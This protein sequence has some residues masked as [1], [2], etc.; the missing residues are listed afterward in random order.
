VTYRTYPHV[1]MADRAVEA[2]GLLHRALAGEI[3]PALVVARPPL[4]KGCD[5]GRT[6]NDGPMVRL[7][8]S[9]A[10]DVQE[11]GLLGI[12]INAGFPE[13]DVWA[14]GSSVIV[15]YDR[16]SCGPDLAQRAAGKIV[17]E[18]WDWRETYAMP[19][20]LADCMAMIDPAQ[21]GAPLVI[22]DY[23]DNPGSGAY[24]DC[25]ALLAALI[26]RGVQNAALSAIWDPAVA[27][28]MAA[29][30]VGEVVTVTIGGKTDATVGGGPLSVTGEIMAQSDGLFTY[31]GPMFAG[32]AGNL[33]PS[34]CLRVGGI[35][36]LIVS[37]R[38][39]SLDLNIFR[40]LGVEPA[41]KSLLAVKSMQH[42]RA[43]FAPIAREII[44]VDA[45]GL[46]TPNVE[47][48]TY[49]NVRRPVWPLD[50]I[51]D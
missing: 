38:V 45:G 9:A 5:D 18:I 10:R 21:A 27:A 12:S 32:L 1:D 7:L 25:T 6:T 34:V 47:N 35:D 50:D 19:V 23:A 39:Q 16:G 17:G 13:A 3:D 11:A 24:G 22:A 31:E 33:G 28:D 44:M 4:I 14:L 49:A 40:A 36:V 30:A 42:F 8:E 20:G 2:C 26:A 15:C 37:E 48:R 29:R 51:N 46:S 41:E 43:A